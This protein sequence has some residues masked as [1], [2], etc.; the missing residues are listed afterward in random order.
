MIVLVNPVSSGAALAAAFDEGGSTHLRLYTSEFA[1][2][3]VGERVLV[4]RDLDTTVDRLSGFGVRHVVAASEFGVALADELAQRLRVGGND[5]RTAAARRDKFLMSQVLRRAGVPVGRSSLVGSRDELDAELAGMAFPVVVKPVNGAGSD[6]CRVC[7]DHS[8]AVRALGATLGVRN[9]MGLPNDAL[10]VQEYL[11][12]P[13]LIVNTV[14]QGGRHLLAD[15]YRCRIDEPDG[16]PVYR[17]IVSPGSLDDDDEEIVAYVGRCLDALGV[18]EG[19]AHTEVRRTEAGPRVVEVNSRVMG[20]CLAPDPYFAA[21]GFTHQHLTAER[22][23]APDRFATRFG[24][25]YRPRRLL[26]KVFLRAHREGV[27]TG[28]PGLPVLRDLPGMHTIVGLPAV[29]TRVRD[30]LLTTGACGIAF[31]VADEEAQLTRSLDLLHGL[32]DTGGLYAVAPDPEAPDRA[33]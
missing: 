17:H 1:P 28:I 2:D 20:P 11:R 25:S 22:Y 5:P 31:L 30:R 18:G 14:S 21:L 19:A 3:R 6:G 29:G 8:E 27:I 16:A 23:L 7:R 24:S 10:L 32:E 15:Y 12:G 4:H 26:A 13:Q 9:L 33:H